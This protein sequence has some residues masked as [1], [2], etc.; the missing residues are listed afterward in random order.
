MGWVENCLNEVK[1]NFLMRKKKQTNKTLGIKMIWSVEL[2]KVFVIELTAPF[3]ETFNW[4]H[5]RELEKYEDLREQ[6]VRNGWITNVLPIKVRFC[7]MAYQLL[8]VI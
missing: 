1:K 3:E 2:K 8:W 7:L 6:C 4:A 5:Q